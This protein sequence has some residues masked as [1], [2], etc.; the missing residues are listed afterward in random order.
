MDVLASAICRKAAEIINQNGWTQGA[1][2]RNTENVVCQ[3]ISG[4]AASFSIYG[5][6]SKAMYLLGCAH[7]DKAMQH[8][9][10]LWQELTSRAARERGQYSG[11]HPLFDFND[12]R[13]R[14]QGEVVGF[15]NDCA[16]A[17]EQA[18]SAKMAENGEKA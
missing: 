1:R 6:V 11:V 12:D 4:D 15:L 18:E 16:Y 7:D 3:I 9:L 8:R 17:L 13:N 5:A 10:D 2:A 14:T